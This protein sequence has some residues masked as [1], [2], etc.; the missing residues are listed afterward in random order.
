MTTSWKVFTMKIFFLMIFSLGILSA[1]SD[2]SVAE[3]STFLFL[4]SSPDDFVGEGNLCLYTEEEGTFSV[5]TDRDF[6]FLKFLFR[7]KLETDD[8]L[9][10]WRGFFSPVRGHRLKPIFYRKAK[11]YQEYNHPGF[12][13]SLVNKPCQSVFGNFEILELNRDDEDL[14]FAVNFLQ[15]CNGRNRPPLFGAIRYRSSKPLKVSVSEI[16]GHP[17]CPESCVYTVKK[18]SLTGK[19]ICECKTNRDCFFHYTSN[20]HDHE[21]YLV[22]KLI[23][24]VDSAEFIEFNY[25][26]NS[27]GFLY[28]ANQ[29]LATIDPLRLWHD[30]SYREMINVL[31][32]YWGDGYIHNGQFKIRELRKNK[33]GDLAELA[34]DFKLFNLEGEVLEGSLRYKSHTPINLIH[35][36]EG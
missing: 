29:L 28:H 4:L 31:C 17:Y 35:P 5:E 24:A 2:N 11:K 1:E 25:S 23:D 16:F 13:F 7:Q 9:V 34:V 32:G 8:Q 30:E 26:E 19:R 10:E 21:E 14:S 3:R 20:I 12:D 18:D 15:H 33:K 6:H 27:T 36:F 22:V